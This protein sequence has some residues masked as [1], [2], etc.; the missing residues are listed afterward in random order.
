M[1]ATEQELL[2]I[3]EVA[4]R[5]S[6][7]RTTVYGLLNSGELRS[8]KLGNSRRVLV[9]DLK[10]YVNSLKN[11][12]DIKQFACVYWTIDDVHS[13]RRDHKLPQWSDDEAEFWLSENE[14]DIRDRMNENGSEI[15][16][17]RLP[18]ANGRRKAPA[19]A[20]IEQFKDK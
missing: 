9:D 15:F 14:E 20:L 7:G 12:T 10:K 18:S 17:R 8:V 4:R 2:N 6:C 5:L 19:L 1:E 3:E 13:Y 16:D 11:P